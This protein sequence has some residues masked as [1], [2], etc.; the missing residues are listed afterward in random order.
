MANE[1]L[2]EARAMTGLGKT[3]LANASLRDFERIVDQVRPELSNDDLASLELQLTALQQVSEVHQD[4]QG[5]IV[6][7]LGLSGEPTPS[8]TDGQGV[9]L[10]NGGSDNGT[11][12]GGVPGDG[13]AYGRGHGKGPVQKP[14]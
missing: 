7:Q 6:S 3:A 13:H 1:R 14:N 9:A 11:G 2:R 8:S 10:G 5:L 4:A 12:N